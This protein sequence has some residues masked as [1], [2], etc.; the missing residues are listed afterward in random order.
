MDKNLDYKTLLENYPGMGAVMPDNVYEGLLKTDSKTI[1][2][3]MDSWK[4]N[5]KENVKRFLPSCGWLNDG[6]VSIGKNKAVIGI[7][8][9]P[10]LKKNKD[11]LKTVSLA[12]GT[13]EYE[14][15]DFILMSSNHQ[16]KDCLEEG[17]IPHFVM[18][19]DA[20]PDLAVQMDVG[21]SGKYTTLIAN[22]LTHPDVIEK[23]KGPVKFIVTRDAELPEYI[24]GLT[25][26]PIS[27]KRCV[28]PGGNILNLSFALGI[29]LFRA[30]AWMCV[31]NDLSY[32]PADNLEDR[33]KGFYEDGD[34]TTNIKSRR[35]EASHELMWG[36]FD[37]PKSVLW[38]PSKDIV[39]WRLKWL[40][41]APQLFFYKT[42]LEANAMI[43]WKHNQQ[44]H[45][46]NC[47]EDGILGVL[48]K[49]GVNI[50]EKYDEKFDPDNWFLMDEVTNG[51]WR[52]RTLED[53]CEEFHNAK[54]KLLGRTVWG[55]ESIIQPAARYA[56]NTG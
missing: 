29:G 53:A 16:I 14:E 52:T 3:L 1:E 50:P 38:T 49:E 17:I 8:S 25:G 51:R 45:I 21:K 26:E 42:W 34:Y 9:G 40:C 31:G 56:T 41:T 33:R 4:D 13:R 24:A 5:I 18:V 37:F 2:H 39:R 35:D 54:Q 36:G 43:L 46:F 27:R 15:Q 47:S 32:S 22:I 10:S 30:S 7:G 55:Q 12:D 44:F 28:V 11:Y 6:Y 20:S 23:W 19:S 48:L